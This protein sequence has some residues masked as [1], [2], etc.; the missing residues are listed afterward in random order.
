MGAGQPAVESAPGGR[1]A[2]KSAVADWEERD[3]P[4]HACR[5]SSRAAKL[6]GMVNIAVF[7]A[8]QPRVG[9]VLLAN[10]GFKPVCRGWQRDVSRSGWQ[11]RQDRGKEV[12][13]NGTVGGKNGTIWWGCG[14]TH[15]VSRVGARGGDGRQVRE[16]AVVK[17]LARRGGRTILGL[18]YH[19]WGRMSRGAGKD[20][21]GGPGNRGYAGMCY[22][23]VVTGRHSSASR[24][25][26]V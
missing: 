23:L 24:H 16:Y 17:V 26:A 9:G 21:R 25:D 11:K 1:A 20:C 19:G 10:A 12:A 15:A 4:R 5:G 13:R 22:R 18:I 6:T 14:G 8:F 2:A 7:A 3:A